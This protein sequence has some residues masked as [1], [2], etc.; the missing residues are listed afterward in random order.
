MTLLKTGMVALT[1]AVKTICRILGAWRVH[2]DAVLVAAVAAATIT[3]AEADS[4]TSYL[5]ATQAA[6]DLLRRITGY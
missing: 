6:C 1:L 3:Q 5:N 4:I 2:I